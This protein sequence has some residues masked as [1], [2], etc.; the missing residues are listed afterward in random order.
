ME[1]MISAFQFVQ[2]DYGFCLPFT[3]AYLSKGFSLHQIAMVV[4]STFFTLTVFKYI[5]YLKRTFKMPRNIISTAP[6][7]EVSIVYYTEDYPKARAA[8]KRNTCFFVG[9]RQSTMAEDALVADK[10]VKQEEESMV[11]IEFRLK[12]MRLIEENLSN[13]KLNSSFLA[14]KMAMST[15][16][17]Y[18]RFKE[19]FDQTPTDVI[20]QVRIT[21]AATLLREENITIN[22]V[23]AEV[24]IVSR[25]YFYK[26][27]SSLYKMTPKVYKCSCNTVENALV[28]G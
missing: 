20:K 19:G 26:E 4:P 2:F 10:L 23:M 11:D 1:I 24:G 28:E 17:F 7:E 6:Y 5:L 8:E 3:L 13:E 14:E 15:R 27:F 18:R 21:K 25:S 9:T 22:N 16:N 12:V